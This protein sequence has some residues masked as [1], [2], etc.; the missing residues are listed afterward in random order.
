MADPYAAADA[1]HCVVVCTDWPEFRELDLARLKRGHGPAR[2]RGRP[3]PAGRRRGDRRRVPLLPRGSRRERAR[4]AGMSSIHDVRVVELTTRTDDRGASPRPSARSGS[5]R[6]ARGPVEPV[7]EPRGGP[8]R[9]P[10]P[11]AAGRLLVRAGGERVH[12]ARGPARRLA[13]LGLPPDDDAGRRRAAPLHPAGRRPRVLRP[14]RHG[15]AVH[16]G[17]RLHRRRRVRR[18]VGRPGARDR[19]ALGRTDPVG[20]RPDEPV[21]GRGAGRPAAQ[22]PR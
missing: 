14:H 16:G 10:L 13:H 12:R 5:R 22:P 9:A 15:H 1:A 6:A 7:P 11:S 21:A 18:G 2:H 17:S 20:A 3:E 19:V 4:R 8:A